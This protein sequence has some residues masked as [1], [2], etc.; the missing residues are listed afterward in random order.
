[1]PNIEAEIQAFIKQHGVLSVS[2]VNRI[3][4]SHT[5]KGLTILTASRAQSVRF[6]AVETGSQARRLIN[7]ACGRVI[8]IDLT[9]LAVGG[10]PADCS[11]NIFWNPRTRNEYFRLLRQAQEIIEDRT[12][13]EERYDREVV[14]WMRKGKSVSK[15]IAKANQKFPKEALQVNDDNLADVQSH[16]EYLA[17]HDLIIEKLRRLE[18]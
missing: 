17:E 10:R 3:I 14:R 18:G 4:G 11:V 7:D 15:A 12:P 9:T 2:M 5:K 16:Y 6:G 13:A 1:M 8:C